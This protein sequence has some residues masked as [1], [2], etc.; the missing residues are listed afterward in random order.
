MRFL[1]A[2]KITHVTHVSLY[3]HE[4]GRFLTH[5]KCVFGFAVI[6]RISVLYTSCKCITILSIDFM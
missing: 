2:N 3:C 5:T 4:R 6:S 1:A